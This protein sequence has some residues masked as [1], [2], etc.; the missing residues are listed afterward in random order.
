MKTNLFRKGISYLLS[1]IIFFFLGPIV[2]TQAVKNE[3]HNLFWAVFITGI[4]FMIVAIIL[5][6]LGIRAVFKS[7]DN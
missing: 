1:S 2:V 3:N 4:I 7:I 5:S 6:F